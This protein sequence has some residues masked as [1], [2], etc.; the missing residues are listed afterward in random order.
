L[1]LYGKDYSITVYAA[2]QNRGKGSV[3]E[4]LRKGM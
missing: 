1:G 4:R 2:K 3:R